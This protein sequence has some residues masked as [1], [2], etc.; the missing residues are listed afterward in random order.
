[1]KGDTMATTKADP[2]RDPAYHSPHHEPQ[3]S[4]ENRAMENR[5]MEDAELGPET[6]VCIRMKAQDR[7]DLSFK[8]RSMTC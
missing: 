1:M 4:M 6:Q 2:Y 8:I 5:A 7:L 3:V